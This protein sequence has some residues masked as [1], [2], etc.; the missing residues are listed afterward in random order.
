MNESFKNQYSPE[1]DESDRHAELKEESAELMAA[2]REKLGE[3]K[4]TFN[5]LFGEEGIPSSITDGM[6]EVRK[7]I[8]TATE[9]NNYIE[10]LSEQTTQKIKI[11]AY[12]IA[13]FKESGDL[14]GIIEHEDGTTEATFRNGETRIFGDKEEGLYED[15]ERYMDCYRLSR[16]AHKFRKNVEEIEGAVIGENK[17]RKLNFFSEEEKRSVIFERVYEEYKSL[18]FTP[19]E[20]RDLVETSNLSKLDAV[21]IADMK[22]LTKLGTIFSKF[23]E[24]DKTK[25]ASLSAALAVPAFVDGYA[26]MMLANAFKGAQIDMTQISLY[27]ILTAAAAGGSL[28]VNKYFQ[29]FLDKNFSKEGGYGEYVVENLSALPG[30]EIG[31]LGTETI[32][33]RV[34]N[35]KSSYEQILRD[36]SQNIFPAAVTLGTSV[37]VLS[38]ESPY[39][40]A[41]TVAGAGLMMIVDKFVRKKG[42]FWEKTRKARQTIEQSEE[43]MAELLNAHMEVVLSGEKDNF[44]KKMEELLSQERVASS[45]KTLLEIVRQKI[46][47]FSGALNMV[48]AGVAGYL[49]GGTPDK[50]IAALAYSRNFQSSIDQMMKVHRNMLES[51]RDM[52]QMEIM[53][54]GYAEEEKEKEEQRVGMSEVSS[55]RITL[56]DVAVEFGGKKILEN[57]NMDIAPGELVSLRGLSGSGK[58]TLL[59]VISG[60]Y[61][62]TGG[63]VE[64]GGVNMEDIKKSGKDSVY[65]KIAYLSQFPY[66]LD[67]SVKENL[68]F[69]IA[70]TVNDDELFSVLKQVGLNKRFPN[71]GEKLKAGRGD[72]GSTSGGETSRIGLART[73]LKMRKDS[74]RIV[75]LDEPTAS[76]DPET[77]KK[78]AE[79]VNLEKLNNPDATFLS[80]SHD[81]DFNELL[82]STKV[83]NIKDG[84]IENSA[85]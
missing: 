26:P 3:L 67:G 12:R 9:E 80:I 4:N 81:P 66:I 32:K 28:A 64:I 79:I 82:Q 58:T 49:S 70:S 39:L 47:Q 18:G 72:I 8:R 78:I 69:G 36:L 19:E 37:A 73:I 54:N 2:K 75:F 83:V 6:L 59:K 1:N 35:S 53:F 74:S 48:V 50:F 44:S 63:S 13:N 52:T 30:H 56:K 71:L 76:V 25:Y 22:I 77:R 17:I 84:R 62:P 27:A 24:G 61:R 20:V 65:G 51:L 85:G 5:E 33:Q 43:Q 45:D 29:R 21:E 57:I 11:L 60:Y 15:L 10:E 23:M 68:L 40:A 34:A 55:N 38:Q 46:G 42:G 31:Q 7:S 41:G 16:N 14:E